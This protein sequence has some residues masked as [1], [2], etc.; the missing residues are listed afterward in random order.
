MTKLQQSGVIIL[1]KL[2]LIAW[3]FRLV[4]SQRR[5]I[6]ALVA[7]AKVSVEFTE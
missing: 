3:L 6:T 2:Q 5:C 7:D 1:N 4:R